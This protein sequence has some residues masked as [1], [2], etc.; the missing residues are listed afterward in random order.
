MLDTDETGRRD[1]LVS[2]RREVVRPRAPVQRPL[3]RVY[4]TINLAGEIGHAL[5]CV[6]CGALG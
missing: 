2:E 5:D 6:G 1:N 4:V 3:Q